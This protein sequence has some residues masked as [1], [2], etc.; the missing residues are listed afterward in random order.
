MGKNRFRIDGVYV[1]D[2][3]CSFKQA[4]HPYLHKMCPNHRTLDLAAY[5]A[6]YW[7][8]HF[9]R[10]KEIAKMKQQQQ[11]QQP[12]TFSSLS[13]PPTAGAADVGSMEVIMQ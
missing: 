12:V 9:F 3:F 11:Q 13:P 10:D 7:H 6:H 8:M 2:G 4:L 1:Y 5:F